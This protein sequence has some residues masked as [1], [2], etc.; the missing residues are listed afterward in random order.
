MAY[1]KG[2]YA[3]G[4]CDR[5]GARYPLADLVWEYKNGTKT[6][7]RIG[8][9]VVDLDHPQNFLGKVRIFDP[10][11]LRDARP[12]TGLTTSRAL[13]SWDPVGANMFYMVGSVGTV[14]VIGD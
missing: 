4:Y 8:K 9:D 13:S 2:K 1:A 3:F 12:D 14:T 7:M 5:T 6:G 11:T 10:Q